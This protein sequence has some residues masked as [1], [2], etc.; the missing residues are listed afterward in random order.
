[1]VRK[2]YFSFLVFVVWV[3]VGTPGFSETVPGKEFRLEHIGTAEGLSSSSVS[4]IIQDREGLLWFSTQAGLNR[5]DGYSIERYE[6][7]PFDE[8]SLSH[9]LIQTMYYEDSGVLWLGTY[10]GL[11]R[12]DIKKGS[13]TKY[14]HEQGS[15]DTLSN[16][17]VV[18]VTRSSSGDLWV[19]TL[20]GLNRYDSERD[21]FT[22]YM[23]G[24]PEEGEL[25][26]DVIRALAVDN[27]GTLWVGTYGGLFR[28]IENDDSFKPFTPGPGGGESLP[29][30]Y[31]MSIL[32]DPDEPDVLWTGT[33]GGGVSKVNTRTGR[34]TTYKLPHNEIYTMM[35][36][37]QNNLWVGTWGNGLY[38]INPHTGKIHVIEN[39]P[40]VTESMSNFSDNVIYSLTEDESGIVWIGTNGSGV[41]KY[42][43]W[44]NSFRSLVHDPNDPNTISK[45]K[46]TAAYFDSNGT[47]WFGTYNGGL[48]K[49]NPKTD[50]FTH[51]THD[52]EEPGS[53]SNNLVNEI[54][55]DSKGNLWI[56]TNEGLNK[57][58]PKS[59]SFERIY[60][61]ST[62]DTIA[63][64]VVFE[65][66]EAPN[67]ELWLGTNTSGVAVY[68]HETG[69]YRVL[70][71][72]PDNPHS[73][74][75]NLVRTI[76][77]DSKGVTWVGTN[78]GLNRYDQKT[79]RFIRYFH[80]I[81]RP[82][83][84]ISSDNIRELL[85]D[86]EGR[87]WIATM[88]GGVSR[89]H[90]ETGSFSY[91]TVKDGLASN[92]VLGVLEDQNGN[93]WFPTNRGISIYD[94]ERRSFHTINESNG[95]L[96]NDLTKAS[97][98]DTEGNFYFGSAKG[99]SIIEDVDRNQSDFVPPIVITEFSVLGK[100]RELIKTGAHSY[101]PVV[102]EYTDSFLSCE[103][104]VLDYSTPDQN[105]YKYKLEGFD[106]EWNQSERNFISYTNLDAGNYT[107]RIKGA[108]SR[109]NWNEKGIV[110]PI[111]VLPPWWK[112]N[113]AYTGYVFLFVLAG[114]IVFL[115]IRKN[116]LEAEAKIA[117][118]ERINRELDHK[119]KERTAEIE[120]SRIQAEEASKAK[121]L[122]LANMSHE[123]R[124]P[125]N[126]LIGMLS[127]L[128]KT[129]LQKEQK[130]Y[131]EYSRISANTLNTL[132]NDL[133]DFERIEAGEL[134]LAHET[135]SLKEAAN[136]IRG[137][138]SNAFEE[139]G[140]T[141][142]VEVHLH[143]DSDVV[144]GDRNRVVQILTNLVSNGLKYTHQG[145]VRVRITLEGES[146]KPSYI[147]EVE[148]T[149]VGIAEDDLDSIFDHFTQLD[150]G[151]TK[152]SRGVGLGLAIVK[153]VTYAMNGNI[154]VQSRLS[155]GTVFRVELPL[156]PA[157]EEQETTASLDK[158]EDT[159]QPQ[160]A[161]ILICE[162]EA[163]NRL[164]I[165]QYLR[166]LGFNIDMAKNGLEAVSKAKEGN[167]S[168]IL[169]D[170]GM[171][172]I[173]GFEATKRIRLWE[174]ENGQ[175][176][177]A[178][179]ALT[180]HT[181]EEDIQKCREAGMNDFI[182]KPIDEKRLKQ[183]IDKW[184]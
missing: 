166:G 43:P 93:L 3:L 177:N 163:I 9:N 134:K 127:L 71:H 85:E 35:F 107:L 170:L 90:R 135:F 11:N 61:D 25:G 46:I 47:G 124:T 74:S 10:G 136:Y 106:D 63:E 184:M 148:D 141:L 96:S 65:I 19:G 78:D 52:P 138:F 70:S 40:S 157:G 27:R 69:Q 73:I 92:H 109:G 31:V 180:A 129:S 82:G 54:F 137:L 13:F 175:K 158:C 108:G 143:N 140:L 91:L 171:P 102:L 38:Q 153:Q 142:D 84:S 173:S 66:S 6:H 49:Y 149:G 152:T 128:S 159:E 110:I 83:S 64:D 4:G 156:E 79:N 39:T 56:G 12:F 21:E 174:R 146:E 33:W 147:F 42:V 62:T 23:K 97:V 26:N 150:N 51:Y 151:Y 126:G 95:L 176:P 121:S 72:D 53:L 139:K 101:G 113:L 160:N 2:K 105:T 130:E 86:G 172:H 8:N 48:N 154:S 44:E 99:V 29:S 59:D 114:A 5:F 16:N 7:D 125:L 1:M 123:I 50:S 60:P 100:R 87:I 14:T 22:R 75:D 111:R 94:P 183:T 179:I 20:K 132:V 168:V 133:L 122:F 68:D 30:P 89:Y 36:D 32:P 58:L 120:K 17:V 155:K 144:K 167:H 162:D 115:R 116:K 145:G 119:V 165:A 81:T 18:A 118:K 169:M 161:S 80:D 45:G 98:Q 131:L 55:R 24:D 178:I 57:Y 76:L 112:T 15:P 103:F 182:S 37:S 164:Y 181:Y 117:E 34:V 88:G 77:H 28:Y 67:G 41:Y 104:S